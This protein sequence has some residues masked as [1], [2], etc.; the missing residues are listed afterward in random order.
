MRPNAP[1]HVWAIDFV[2][3]KLSSNRTC[4]MLTVVDEYIHQALAVH[5]ACKVSSSDAPEALYPLVI[6]HR[7]PRYARY[8]NGHEFIAEVVP[9]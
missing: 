7:K 8:D 5:V 6:K 1:N 2:H 3:D 4:K 9:N